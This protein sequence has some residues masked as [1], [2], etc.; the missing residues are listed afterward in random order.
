MS[1]WLLQP[2]TRLRAAMEA[3]GPGM[4]VQQASFG[5]AELAALAAAYNT[6]V[7]RQREFEDLL[8][9]GERRMRDVTDSV[10]AHIAHVDVNERCTF[11][12]AKICRD[13]GMN[14]SAMIGRTI[15][16]NRGE[17]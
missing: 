4:P 13:F 1:G 5:S 10:P 3:S 7:K 15:R 2:L 17:L 6:Q 8:Q 12:N 9:A 11:A 14:P 16:E